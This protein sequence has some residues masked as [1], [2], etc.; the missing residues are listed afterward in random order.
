M[1]W[2]RPSMAIYFHIDR[3]DWE[4]T[5]FELDLD[6]V[7]VP[8][9]EA[10]VTR[11]HEIHS[12]AEHAAREEIRGAE[13][14]DDEA[15][16]QFALD[17]AKEEKKRAQERERVVGWLALVDLVMVFRLKVNK[18]LKMVTRIADARGIRQAS[19]TEQRGNKSRRRTVWLF[20]LADKYRRFGIDLKSNPAFTVI[21]ELVL[22]RNDVEH[23]GGTLGQIYHEYFPNPRFSDGETI[24]FSNQDFRESV[25]LLK[26]Y[27]DWIVR[28][29]RQFRDGEKPLGPLQKPRPRLRY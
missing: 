23:E 25:K 3:L 20:P 4:A 18:L 2:E 24:V 22:A 11:L 21:H 17:L 28:E 14:A 5:Y 29:V 9:H 16:H 10:A 26:E 27:V 13:L 7:I 19:G 8:I 1:D 15:E 6:E 12:D